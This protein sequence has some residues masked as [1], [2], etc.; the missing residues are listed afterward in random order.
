MKKATL[1]AALTVALAV[2]P[3]SAFAVVPDPVE[4]AFL[5]EIARAVAEVYKV[6]R[7]ANKQIRDFRNLQAQMFPRDTL[8]SIQTLFRSVR[9]LQDELEQVGCKWK[10]SPRV[11]RI[12][13]GLLRRGPLCRPE[14]EGMFGVPVPGV[15]ADLVQARQY[16]AV[17][18]M[19]VVATTV[20]ASKQWTD[21]ADSYAGRT[22]A[23]NVSAGRAIRYIGAL[24]ALELQQAVRQNVH[25]AELL[26]AAQED[27]DATMRKDWRS[28]NY[29]EQSTR[30]AISA[31]ELLGRQR[32]AGSEVLGR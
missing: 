16:A 24:S 23:A 19:N 17:R 2:L 14:Y 7:D 10:F 30:W 25:E 26:S 9:S 27:L 8:A 6:M 31:F 11:E 29:A 32:P 21:A 13:L 28:Q 12:R 3:S 4:I 18:R 15:D 22:R 1:A 20:G 5:S